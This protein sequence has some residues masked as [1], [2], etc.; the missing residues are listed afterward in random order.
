MRDRRLTLQ[1]MRW[2]VRKYG[3]QQYKI[4]KTTSAELG[5][6]GVGIGL[7]FEYLKIMTFY[8]VVMS[9]CAIPSIFINSRGLAYAQRGPDFSVFIRSSLGNIGD[10]PD[11]TQQ[12]R[13]DPKRVSG[14]G[15][16]LRALFD[17]I[18]IF[19]LYLYIYI[20]YYMYVV[21]YLL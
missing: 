8:F 11:R 7:Y 17:S 15:G 9:I 10:H 21:F 19:V 6:L 1:S 4:Y 16:Q 20:I 13:L 18:Q 12:L 2:Q 14:C 3:H 5:T